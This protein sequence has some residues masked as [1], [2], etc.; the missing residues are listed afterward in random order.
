[1]SDMWKF[2]LLSNQWDTMECYGISKIM[3]DVYLWNGTLIQQPINTNQKLLDDMKKTVFD[4]IIKDIPLEDQ[5]IQV[6]VPRA[7][8]SM[9]LVGDP[10]DYIM[11]FGGVTNETVTS[12][13]GFK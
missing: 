2:N 9:T 12:S 8:H 13:D 10:Q 1:M 4:P 7:G 3:R 11:N 5:D 6:P